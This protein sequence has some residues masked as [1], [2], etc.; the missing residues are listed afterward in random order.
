MRLT[1]FGYKLI[2]LYKMRLP[3]QNHNL[4]PQLKNLRSLERRL[5]AGGLVFNTETSFIEAFK[6]KHK[7]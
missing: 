6:L 5:I 4:K 2:I 1:A 3:H 7:A